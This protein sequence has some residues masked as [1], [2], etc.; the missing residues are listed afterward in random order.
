MLTFR[1]IFERSAHLYTLR[2]Q[3]DEAGIE[4]VDNTSE[5]IP[6]VVLEMEQRIAGQWVGDDGD[7]ILQ[8]R[9]R[10]IWP[11]HR[12]SRPLQARTGIEFLRERREWLV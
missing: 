7:D 8:D 10:A 12:N 9:F 5:E 1:E 11:L 4:P 3:D 2:S 6:A